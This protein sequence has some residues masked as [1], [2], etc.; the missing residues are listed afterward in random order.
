MYRRE[1]RNEFDGDDGSADHRNGLPLA[2]GYVL[3]EDVDGLRHAVRISSIQLLSDGD[4][5]G[6][7]TV[8]V[9]AGRSLMI[10]QS[11]EELL[12]Q[13]DFRKPPYHR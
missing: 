5:C 8:A 12:G 9:V 3:L 11:L 4:Q 1:S 2:P 6:D 7:S 13:M 10:S